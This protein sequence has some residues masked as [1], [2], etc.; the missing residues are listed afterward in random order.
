MELHTPHTSRSLHIPA[1]LPSILATCFWLV[2]VFWSA[3]WQPI[4]ATMYCIFIMLRHSIQCPKQWDGVPPQAPRPAG[5]L[6]NIQPVAAANTR[7]I[8]ASYPQTAATSGQSPS[9]LSFFMGLFLA[10]QTGKPT[11]AP[12]NPMARALHESIGSSSTMILG[13]PWPTH[14]DRG[15]SRW[16]VGQLWLLLLLCVCCVFVCCVVTYF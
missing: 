7:L 15:Q 14:G 10:P 16:R 1:M 12:P 13:R 2:V 8:V 11:M 3:D 6:S 5:L 9:H 4:N